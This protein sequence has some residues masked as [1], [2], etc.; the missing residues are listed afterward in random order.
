MAEENPKAVPVTTPMLLRALLAYKETSVLRTALE[1]RLFD[2]LAAGPA[3]AGEVAPVIGAPERSTRILLRALASIGF[4][5]ESGPAESP[6]YDLPPGGHDLLVTSSPRYA[7][8]GALVA[9][10]H[11]E[12]ESMGALTDIVRS[13]RTPLTVDA[14]SPGFGY[15]H[16]FAAHG[17]FATRPVAAGAAD[18][19][20]QWSA[21]R[22]GLRILELGCGHALFGLE[23][24]RRL[25]G[26]TLTGVDWE[27]VLPAARKNAAEAGLGDR[28]TL[29]PGDLFTVDLAGPYDVVVAANMLPQF[30]PEDGAR[31]LARGVSALVPG[32]IGVAAGFTVGDQSATREYGARMLSLL[33]L[34]WTQHGEVPTTAGYRDIFA[35]A[36]IP[37]PTVLDL[38]GLPTRLF[39]GKRG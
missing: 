32:G 26:S 22:D 17:T 14:G 4:V 9:A 21:G 20:Q 39:L 19:V 35:R 37:D 29:I 34:A 13:G 3:A 27:E 5:V 25:P 15:W 2:A 11:L 30:S 33:M 31:L 36:G 6:R 28:T 8:G 1:L 12:W 38:P 18:A 10:S 23:M 24:C 16:D 7:G